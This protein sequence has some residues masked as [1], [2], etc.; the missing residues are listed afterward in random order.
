MVI[1]PEG[2][3]DVPD[4]LVVPGFDML[5]VSENMKNNQKYLWTGLGIGIVLPIVAKAAYGMWKN[6]SESA[7][8][9]RAR[10]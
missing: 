5:P 1:I 6:R 7:A 9:T 4:A 3:F 10:W 2:G 8:P